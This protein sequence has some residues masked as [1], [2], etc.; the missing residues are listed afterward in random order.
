MDSLAGTGGVALTAG[1]LR[2]HLPH[3]GAGRGR[4]FRAGQGRRVP[5]P[6]RFQPGTSLELTSAPLGRPR[7]LAR[8][9]SLGRNFGPRGS[10][11]G[12][13]DPLSPGAS[14]Q[15]HVR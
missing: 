1:P 12:Q 7:R 6:P 15:L 2:P 10:G 14:D 8:S 11:R 4:L 3:L 9:G 5:P 13:R